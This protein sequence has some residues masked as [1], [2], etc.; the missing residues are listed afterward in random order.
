MPMRIAVD[1]TA[2]PRR[3]GGAGNY[4]LRLVDALGKLN[5][6]DRFYV[7]AKHGDVDR[8]RSGDG[9]NGFEPVAVRLRNRPH[10]LVWEQTMLPML[11]RRLEIDLLHSPHYTMP[12]ASRAARVVTFH[13]LIFFLHPEY[14]DRI[15]VLFFQQMI[16]RAAAAA[17]HVITDSAS[18]SADAARLLGMDPARL[19][20]VHLAADVRFRRVDDRS[21]VDAVLARYRLTPPFLLAV[22]T[23]EPRKN[24]IGAIRAFRMLRG[25]GF[26]GRLAIAGA[27]GWQVGAV[28]EEAARELGDAVAFLGYVP[29][30]ELPILYSACELFLYPSFYEGFGLPV[31]E[32]MACGAAVVTSD[33][34]SMPEI[35]GDAALL[36][37]PARAEDIAAKAGSVLADDGLRRSLGERAMRRA[38]LFSWDKTAEQTYAVYRRVLADAR[39]TA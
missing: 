14:H 10:R 16:R 7:I 2:L 3:A 24:L 6:S 34:S 25:K 32:A 4:I 17:D 21:A 5:T 26:N 15:K 35:A 36:C 23:I 18:T 9:R 31:L 13:D 11:L 39:R 29:D 19:T 27:R 20:T 8:L 33:R 1:A 38:R 12:I 28:F 37:D 22:C 30:D